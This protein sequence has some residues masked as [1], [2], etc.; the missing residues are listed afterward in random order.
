MLRFVLPLFRDFLTSSYSAEGRDTYLASQVKFQVL[1]RVI[2]ILCIARSCRG[3]SSVPSS[4]T[5]LPSFFFFIFME[6]REL[7]SI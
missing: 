6:T 3:D 5:V 2:N 7:A 1:E 4:I